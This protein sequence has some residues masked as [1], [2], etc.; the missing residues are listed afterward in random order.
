VC[1]SDLPK[2]P[3]P[4]FVRI[5]LVN[6]NIKILRTMED[7]ARIELL[8]KLGSGSYGDVWVARHFETPDS[9]TYM[10]VKLE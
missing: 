1:S 9:P 7:H 8:Q 4:R 3:K 6:I 2:T 10:A 5:S